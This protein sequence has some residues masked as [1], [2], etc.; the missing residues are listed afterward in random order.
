MNLG[1]LIAMG[2]ALIGAAP[3]F[4]QDFGNQGVV[5][6]TQA[7]VGPGVLLAKIGSLPCSYDVSTNSILALKEAGVADAVIAAMVERC[8]GASKAQGAV[9]TGSDPASKRSAGL[10]IDLGTETTHQLV[11]IRP[12][13]ASGGRT[14]G[15]GSLLFPF[16]VKLG[17][18]RISA[19]TAATTSRPKFYFYFETD[20][21]KVGDFGTSAT[22]S[23]QS[24][25]EF[26]LMRF[27]EKNGQ[28]EMVVAKQKLFSGSIGIDP[29]DAIQFS[30]EEIGDGAF[31][32]SPLD[33]LKP[34]EY[35]FVLRAGSD[36]YRIYDFRVSI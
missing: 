14:T 28:R 26:S 25:T 1:K 23:A 13:S 12:T 32:V 4:A 33:P 15:N 8:I 34:G 36:A 22:V 31:A 24:P 2:V 16:R 10:Y 18:P 7:G 5:T 11:K 9:G 27:K 30:V 17:I 19:Q 21:P 20:D 35:G 29:K 3:A 6:L